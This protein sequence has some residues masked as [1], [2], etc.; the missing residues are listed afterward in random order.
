MS[1]AHLKL[2]LLLA[3]FLGIIAMSA[4]DAARQLLDAYDT[5]NR[6]WWAAQLLGYP[7]IIVLSCRACPT[8]SNALVVRSEPAWSSVSA[9]GPLGL[10]SVCVSASVAGWRCVSLTYRSVKLN[11]KLICSLVWCQH[12]AQV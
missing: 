11:G 7:A 2:A 9:C 6:G 4:V 12:C 10:A 8:L 1:T 5:C 3:L